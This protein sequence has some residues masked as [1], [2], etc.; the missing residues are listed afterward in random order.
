MGIAGFVSPARMCALQEQ[1]P[2]PTHFHFHSK[3]NVAE[4]VCWNYWDDIIYIKCPF[5]LRE[6]VIFTKNVNL[7]LVYI[8]MIGTI[9]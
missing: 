4:N 7:E 3:W 6:L 1:R 8:L 9:Y 2:R 5:E